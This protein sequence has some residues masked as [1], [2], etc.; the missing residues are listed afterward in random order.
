VVVVAVVL[1]VNVEVSGVAPL[2]VTE[3]GLRTHV[4]TLVA[5]AG[6]VV[7]AQVSGTVPV[8][9]L[10]GVTVMVAVFPLDAPW[11]NETVPLLLSVTLGTLT[12]TLTLV[13]S[14]MLPEVPVT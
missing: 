7:S 10:V 11:A 12:A 6:W 1:T 2:M 9:P 3:V 14:L 4:G 8:K 5:P 13:D